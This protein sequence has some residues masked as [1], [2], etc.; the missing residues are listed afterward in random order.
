M[1]WELELMIHYY[2]LDEDQNPRCVCS[3]FGFKAVCNLAN[4]IYASYKVRSR[5]GPSLGFSLCLSLLE[6]SPLQR[7]RRTRHPFYAIFYAHLYLSLCNTSKRRK[8]ELA[9]IHTDQ[10]FRCAPCQLL[11]IKWGCRTWKTQWK[12]RCTDV[13]SEKWRK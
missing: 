2:C 9:S 3:S 5:N 11:L 7:H 12:D 13:T 4:E 6:H 1:V 10:S 8:I